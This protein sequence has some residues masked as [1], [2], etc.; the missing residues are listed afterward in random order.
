MLTRKQVLLLSGSS[1]REL[2]T[3]ATAADLYQVKHDGE[4]VGEMGKIG[5]GILQH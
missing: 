1:Y 2:S 5:D 3:R 4:A